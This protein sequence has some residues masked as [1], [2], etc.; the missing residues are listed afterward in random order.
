M[1]FEKKKQMSVSYTDIFPGV[2]E[3][4]KNSH[5]AYDRHFA[6]IANQPNWLRPERCLIVC[7]CDKCVSRVS[8]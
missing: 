1:I 6:E 2:A 8:M 4:Y 7:Q 5:C 3:W